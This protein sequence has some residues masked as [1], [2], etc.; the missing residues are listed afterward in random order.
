MERVDV[1]ERAPRRWSPSRLGSPPR[2]LLAVIA[3][4]VLAGGVTAFVAGGLRHGN[5]QPGKAN[6]RVAV[7]PSACTYLIGPI[8]RAAL[9]NGMHETRQDAACERPGPAQAGRGESR[10][11]SPPIC[12]ALHVA[13]G[14]QTSQFGIRH[15]CFPG[16]S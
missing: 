13:P 7:L 14:Q 6:A 9:A 15:R 5:A 16:L 3:V 2:W 12:V 10:P 1:L 11:G 4:L 8:S